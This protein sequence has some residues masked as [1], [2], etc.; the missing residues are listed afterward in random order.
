MNLL[1]RKAMNK[2][3]N[4]GIIVAGIIALL[5]IWVC[6]GFISAEWLTLYTWILLSGGIFVI[7]AVNVII[8]CAK[9]G[10]NEMFEPKISKT[11]FTDHLKNSGLVIPTDLLDSLLDKESKPVELSSISE[12]LVGLGYKVD[13]IEDGF[14]YFNDGNDRYNL[15]S[16]W[17]YPY[18]TNFM[19][20]YLNYS[21]GKEEV[22]ELQRIA[23][24]VTS[25]IRIAKVRI[26]Y[27]NVNDRCGLE[28]AADSF[29][30]GSENIRGMILGLVDI[31]QRA[32]TMIWEKRESQEAKPCV[33][34]KESENQ[35]GL[36]QNKTKYEC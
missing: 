12:L 5:F 25:E 8:L 16:D 35:I 26:R 11:E 9:N 36:I 22:E 17:M 30:S 32:N 2:Q 3:L 1:I 20:V 19:G 6:M 28:I 31:L 24:L 4:R 29:Y 10:E 14:I 27:D 13:G 7:V 34:Y 21:I 15:Y 33:D 23:N 18:Q